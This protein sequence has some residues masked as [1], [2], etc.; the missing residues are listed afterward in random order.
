M[1]RAH[2]ITSI[3]FM[4]AIL[5]SVRMASASVAVSP[6]SA[7]IKPGAQLQFTA[8]GALYDIV[9]WNLSGA[10]CS[11]ISCGAITSNGLYTAPPAAPSPAG[12]VVV[13]TSLFDLTQFGSAAVTIG[14]TAPVGVTISPTLVTLAKSGK[15]QFTANVTGTS[16]TAVN[17]TVSGVGCVA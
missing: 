3:V 6:S 13:A 12:V 9:I 15:Q 17:W 14:A 4:V 8:T 10:G 2:K 7:Q 1:K 5:I 11:G 16:N